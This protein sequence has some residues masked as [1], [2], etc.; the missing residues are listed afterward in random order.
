MSKF[1]EV[2]EAAK[3]IGINPE[4]DALR[5]TARPGRPP[6]SNEVLLERW[7]ADPESVNPAQRKR[8]I[9]AGLIE[10]GPRQHGPK[11]K[12]IEEVFEAFISDPENISVAYRARLVEAGMIV[13]VPAR[14][15]VAPEHKSRAGLIKANLKRAAARKAK[16]EAKEPASETQ[17]ETQAEAA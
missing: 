14:W 11:A 12:P 1:N 15:D 6:I 5:T 4:A 16:E 10:V 13:H 2:I 8:L 7:N 3:K 9:E 17:A